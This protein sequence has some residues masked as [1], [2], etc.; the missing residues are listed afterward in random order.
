MTLTPKETE[1]LHCYAERKTTQQI[2]LKLKIHK[3]CLYVHAQHIRIKTGIKNLRDY[4]ACLRWL[5]AHPEHTSHRINGPTKRQMQL[6][7]LFADGL[8]YQGIA[9]TMG[10]GYQTVVNQMSAARERA[11]LP[12]VPGMDRLKQ[13]REYLNGEAVTMDDPAFS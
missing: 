12:N 5:E 2:T 1:I 9:N 3:S 4:M 11:G 8:S 7:Q 10:V 13:V 6:L